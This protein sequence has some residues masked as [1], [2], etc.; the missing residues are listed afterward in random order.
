MNF[1]A[2][3]DSCEICED[4]YIGDV[5]LIYGDN[6]ICHLTTLFIHALLTCDRCIDMQSC[7]IEIA[8]PQFQQR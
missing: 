3:E 1:K 6:M 5:W 2:I 4:C 7:S 8:N